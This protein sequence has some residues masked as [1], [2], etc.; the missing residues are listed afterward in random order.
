M[1]TGYDRFASLIAD[2]PDLSICRRFGTLAAEDLLY[3]QAE[4]LHLE[5]ELRII[6]E[7][8]DQDLECAV[9]G[10]QRWWF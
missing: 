3:L 10:F 1:K 6:E 9:G 2:Y 7:Q 4:L 5:V 8:D